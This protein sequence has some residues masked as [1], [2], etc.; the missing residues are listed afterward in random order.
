MDKLN[1][2]CFCGT[3]W[4]S[5]RETI[6]VYWKRK[7]SNLETSLLQHLLVKMLKESVVFFR[8]KCLLMCCT[9]KF[10]PPVYSS[11]LISL[12]LYLLEET[13]QSTFWTGLHQEKAGIWW[14]KSELCHVSDRKEIIQD[15]ARGCWDRVVTEAGGTCS[16]KQKGRKLNVVSRFKLR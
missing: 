3:R 15:M 10:H 5:A 13:K 2:M 8:S 6:A 9:L 4:D 11:K 16:N 7:I 14:V 12:V 1:M